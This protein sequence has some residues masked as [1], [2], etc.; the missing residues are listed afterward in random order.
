[1]RFVH[2]LTLTFLAVMAGWAQTSQPASRE[3]PTISADGLRAE[4]EA[5]RGQ[6]VVL[7]MWA[8]WCGPCVEEFPD[9][10]TFAHEATPE[11]VAVIAISSDFPEDL[12]SQVIPFL[13]ETNPPFPVFLQD[14]H[15]DIFIPAVDP[16][17]TGTYPH[18]VVFDRAGNIS[19]RIGVF[20]SA[21]PLHEA[22]TRALAG[23]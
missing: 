7:N 6:V 15:E 20:H 1:M 9:L 4:L 2:C 23:N 10:I 11:E 8:T 5:R 19:S 12:E 16:E 3:V 18:T 14:E 21:A 13:N 22:V 17:W